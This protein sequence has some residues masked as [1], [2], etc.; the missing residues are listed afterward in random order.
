MTQHCGTTTL[1]FQP[2]L[3]IVVANDTQ[4]RVQLTIFQP[5]DPNQNCLTVGIHQAIES[6]SISAGEE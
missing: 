5:A 3:L 4:G 2:C 1:Q 6:D